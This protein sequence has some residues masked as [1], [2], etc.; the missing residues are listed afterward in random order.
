MFRLGVP[1][2]ILFILSSC[3][4]LSGIFHRLELSHMPQYDCVRNAIQSVPNVKLI[5]EYKADVNSERAY[6]YLVKDIASTIRFVHRDDEN[7]FYHESL[8]AGYQASKGELRAT[9]LLTLADVDAVR[10][11][12][13]EVENAIAKYCNMDLSDIERSCNI[14]DKN[15]SI[16]KPVMP[17]K[18]ND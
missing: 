13:I 17:I 14:N 15:C 9:R 2:A 5:K 4:W 16:P 8:D 1:F 11:S 3:S 6:T 7:F 10:P 18:T 12:M